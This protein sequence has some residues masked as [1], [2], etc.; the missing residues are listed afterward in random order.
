MYVGVTFGDAQVK[1]AIEVFS[2]AF[3]RTKSLATAGHLDPPTSHLC[4]TDHV[5]LQC[6]IR[7]KLHRASFPANS[8]EP[9]PLVVVSLD[10][11]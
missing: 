2:M 5:S 4:F 1:D 3:P 11:R 6:Q 7:V 10:S 8:S 9:F